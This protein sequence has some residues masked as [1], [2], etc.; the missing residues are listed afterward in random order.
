MH[1][2]IWFYAA[3]GI[4]GIAAT[5]VYRSNPALVES[6]LI[7][8]ASQ[9]QTTQ[10]QNFDAPAVLPTEIRRTPLDPASGDP[11]ALL[12]APSPPVAKAAPPPAAVAIASP[13]AP[14]P[15]PLNLR[16]AGR[17]VSPDGTTIIYAAFGET[18][19]QLRTGQF[20]PNGYRIDAIT[21][22]AV[23][24]SFPSMGTTARLDL[25][26]PPKYETR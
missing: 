12:P 6:G 19:L 7:S 11:F 22:R 1:G 18:S 21:D 20:L 5:A 9:P 25:P 4:A 14:T 8:T 10:P 3:L 16:F 23:E 15:P 13:V 17:V 24:L 26:D 2:R